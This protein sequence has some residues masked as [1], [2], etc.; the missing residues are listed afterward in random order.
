MA[1]NPTTEKKLY[2]TISEVAE[3]FQVNESLLRYWEKEF[4]TI[5]PKKTGRNIR[6]Y[7][8]EDI[9]Q[10]RL[11]YN[12][13]KVK[14]MKINAARD[15]LKSNKSGDRQVSDAVDILK[16]IRNEL[17]AIRNELNDLV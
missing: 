10:V 9:E 8:A 13:V 5:S 4:P 15:V 1:L 17:V 2:Y 7:T 16:G 11:V 6:R 3:M 12:L 14:G